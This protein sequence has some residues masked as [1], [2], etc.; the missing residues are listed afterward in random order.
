MDR[1]VLVRQGSGCQGNGLAA[2]AGLLDCEITQVDES[3]GVMQLTARPA[4]TEQCSRTDRRLPV[5]RV[6]TSRRLRLGL[7][8]ICAEGA[9]S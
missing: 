6:R 8:R 2:S 9:D 3:S 1:A 7:D 4:L 5:R